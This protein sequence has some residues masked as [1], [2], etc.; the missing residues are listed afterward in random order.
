MLAIVAA[1]FFFGCGEKQDSELSSLLAGAKAVPPAIVDPMTTGSVEGTVFLD[2]PLAVVRPIDMDSEAACAKANRPGTYQG[3]VVTGDN[4]SLANVA[5]YVKGGLSHY[6][7]ATP[8][9]HVV[10]DQK[11]CM[12]TP[13]I[14]ALMTHQDLEI[15][16][17]DATIHNVHAMPKI[18]VEWNKAQ[19]AGGA[20][21]ETSFSQPELPIPFMCNVHPWM[22]AFIF[23][24]DNPYYSVTSGQGKFELKNLPPG[25]YTVEAWQ[26]KF[27]TQ[28]QTVTVAP[29]QSE[30]GG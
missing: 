4:A 12:Y 9:D 2:G 17:D 23:V 11:G 16:N 30:A 8:T 21:L 14:V 28:A 1:L 19:R 13:R 3:S 27:G 24:F 29:R 18:N 25:T 22:R 7:F 20:A 10:L 15:R 26:E 6:R 5:V